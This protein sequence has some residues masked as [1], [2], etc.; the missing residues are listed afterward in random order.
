MLQL[1]ILANKWKSNLLHQLMTAEAMLK[2]KISHPLLYKKLSIWN[3]IEI[4]HT[5]RIIISTVL[6]LFTAEMTLTITC[7][8]WKIKLGIFHKNVHQQYQ[9]TL[10]T[11]FYQTQIGVCV[12]VFVCVYIYIYIYIYLCVYFLL[13]SYKK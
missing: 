12:C 8:N 11:C 3:Q 13:G 7:K 6:Q 2:N 5:F 9:F 10:M 1:T 4:V